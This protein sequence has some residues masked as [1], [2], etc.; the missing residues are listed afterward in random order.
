MVL[1][2][3]VWKCSRS[4]SV[5]HLED[6]PTARHKRSICENAACAEKSERDV[7]GLA[8][9]H[10]GHDAQHILLLPSKSDEEV[11]VFQGLEHLPGDRRVEFNTFS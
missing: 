1:H 11:L 8:Y 10:W 7:K 5:K 4:S 3:T 6:E 2:S 9:A